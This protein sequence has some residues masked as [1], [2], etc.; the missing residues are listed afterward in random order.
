MNDENL[1]KAFQ[2][3][4]KKASK[5]DFDLP[6]DTMLQF[7]AYYKQATQEAMTLN[8]TH[9]HNNLRSAFKLNAIMQI[10]HL[11]QNEAK[12]KYIELVNNTLNNYKPK[13]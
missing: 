8:Y 11:S 3:A 4:F 13:K 9:N 12:L 1:N 2:E 5:I 6:Q 10:S 7:Y